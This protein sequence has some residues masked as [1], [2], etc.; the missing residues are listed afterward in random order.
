MGCHEATK[1][2]TVG[3]LDL[4]RLKGGEATGQKKKKKK[5]RE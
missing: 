1:S 4:E 3:E 2:W 5:K